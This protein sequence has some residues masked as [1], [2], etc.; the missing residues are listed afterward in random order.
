MLDFNADAHAYQK[1][2]AAHLWNSADHNGVSALWLDPGYG[3]T[4][5]VLHAFKALKDHGL[6]KTMLVVAPLRV[7]QTVWAQEIDEWGSLRGLVAQRLHGTKKEKWLTRKGVDI[8]IINYE[9]I[10]WFIKMAKA[11]KV[12][13][14][15]VICFD[16]VRRMKNSQGLR[17]KAARPLTKMAKYKWGLTG[18]PASNG[19]MDLFGQFLILDDGEALGKYITK[20]RMNYFEQGYDGFSW[21]PRP[22][23]QDLIED[24]I[25]HYVYRAQGFLD[26]P[27]EVLDN[28]KIV[29]PPAAVKKY[30]EMK[31]HLLLDLQQ[32][33]E[34]ITAANAAVLV[35]KLKQMANGR[36]YDGNRNV[37]EI[38][39]AKAEA[40]SELIDELGDEQLLIAYEYNHDLTQLKELLG[41]DLP[42]LGAGVNEKTAMSHVEKW[43]SGEIRIMAAHPASAGHGLNLQKSGAHHILWFGPTVDLDH[44]I[45]FIRRILR[46]G[47]KASHVIVHTF[48]AAGTVDESVIVARQTKDGLQSGLLSALT[49]EFGDAIVVDEE[50]QTEESPMTDLAFKSD[51]N[52]PAN[53][54][55]GG[56]PAEPAQTA[57]PA[58]LFGGGA[59]AQP[60]QTAAPTNPF[61]GGAP[62]QPAQ[63]TAAPTNPFGGGAPA[64][65]SVLDQQVAIQNDVAAAPM[66]TPDASTAPPNPFGVAPVSDNPTQVENTPAVSE[67]TVPV[68]ERGHDASV[69]ALTSDEAPAIHVPTAAPAGMVPLYTFVPVDKLDKVL[70][71]IGRAVK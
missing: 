55:G 71:A 48:V 2:A 7:A 62:A 30:K 47:S 45:Q 15:D 14:I 8:W 11:G 54:F 66:P 49:A 60:A 50:T 9:A 24:R 17:F 40:L 29:L 67:S 52:Q 20:Y 33:G 64:Q 12:A 22:G 63:T 56:A 42:Y 41:D 31:Q 4:T 27:E 68:T 28:R 38:H 59:P 39:S 58:D 13:P 43:N 65:T 51:A 3:K 23:A 46:Q 44:Y 57:A 5:T 37:V 6:V 26:L 69:V 36:V 61:G 10:P 34:K 16:E 35:G 19:L 18:T 1:N 53:P 32:N 25:K 21:V 70:S